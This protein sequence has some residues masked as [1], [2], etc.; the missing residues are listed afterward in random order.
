M[1]VEVSSSSLTRKPSTGTRSPTHNERES[2]YLSTADAGGVIGAVAAF[3]F[4]VLA[5][6]VYLVY[7]GD[8][9]H[10]DNGSTTTIPNASTEQHAVAV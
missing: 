2:S 8:G 3:G 7:R 4:C 10:H 5:F 6:I 9:S 1:A